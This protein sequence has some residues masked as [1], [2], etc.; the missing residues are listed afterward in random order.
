MSENGDFSPSLLFI[1]IFYSLPE[2]AQGTS[3]VSL[4]NYPRMN[5]S[6]VFHYNH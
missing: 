2:W 6:N 1:D 3:L 4:C 5:N